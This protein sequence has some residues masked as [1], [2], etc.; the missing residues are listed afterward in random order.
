[1]SFSHWEPH[2]KSRASFKLAYEYIRIYVLTLTC[3]NP[4]KESIATS[5]T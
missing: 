1:M 4:D 2:Q 3:E 5:C